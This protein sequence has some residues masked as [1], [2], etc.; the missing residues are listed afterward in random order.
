MPDNGEKCIPWRIRREKCALI[1]ID[2]Q[3]DFLKPGG[4]LYYNDT[5]LKA[6][7]NIKRL[8]DFCRRLGIPVIYTKTLLK[9]GFNISPL[10]VCY[11]P[12][13][14]QKGMREGTWGAEIIGELLPLMDEQVVFKHRYDAFYNTNLELILKN[15]RGLSGV[16]TVIIT[17][18]VTNVCCESTA[19]GAFMRDYKVVFVSDAN[20]AFDEEAHRATLRNISRFFGRVMDTETLQAALAE[21]ENDLS[22]Y[23]D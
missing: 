5:P 22:S 2:M 8:I 12:V 13:L 6:V 14:M 18:T 4:V 17:G 16:D 15:V 20:G 7:P 3:N 1:V 21:G 9:D 23:M 11:Q 19:R 10:E